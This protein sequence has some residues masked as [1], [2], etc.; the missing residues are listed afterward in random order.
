MD[1]LE[2]AIYT[3]FSPNLLS[4][5]LTL[6]VTTTAVAGRYTVSMHQSLPWILRNTTVPVILDVRLRGGSFD[7]RNGPPRSP[8]IPKNQ[9]SSC[10]CPKLLV[11]HKHCSLGTLYVYMVA[12][13]SVVWH[14]TTSYHSNH[15]LH[16]SPL[17][18]PLHSS[19]S[20]FS[21]T[22]TMSWTPQHSL[23]PNVLVFT[24]EFIIKCL[25]EQ[26]CPT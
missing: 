13:G 17:Q 24:I 7:A 20:M 1:R 22:N 8:K 25:N 15:Q 14:I 26:M 4:F 18:L 11:F 5:N 23:A 19:N 2:M 10:L 6:S 16:Y 3:S 12:M 21:R 9:F